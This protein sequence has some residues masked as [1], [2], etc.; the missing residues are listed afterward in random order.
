MQ[1][2]KD[3]ISA[4]QA[5]ANVPEPVRAIVDALVKAGFEAYLVGGCVRDLLQGAPVRDFDVATSARPEAVLERF[6]RA[7]PIGLQHGT[8]MIPTPAG[9][10]DVTSFRAGPRIED[11]LAH[12]DFTLNA[13]AADLERGQV[14]DPHGGRKDLAARHLRPV[15]SAAARFAEDPLRALRGI[16]LAVTHGLTIDAATVSAMRGARD[17]LRRVPRERV[18]REIEEILLS[19]AAPRGLGLLRDAGLEG[20]LVPEAAPDTA[21]VIAALP[22]DLALRLAA[23]LRG[24]NPGAVL[25]RLRFPR[26]LVKRVALLVRLHPVDE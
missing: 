25:P 17:A 9:P 7:I 2:S 13:L 5:L 4:E 18:R 24:G 8:V 15:G 3:A 19:P 14:L 10:T 23:W 6:P 11:D 21:R 20:D 22:P 12:R 26:R 16:R 1:S